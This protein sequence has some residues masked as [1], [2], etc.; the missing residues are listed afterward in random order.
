MVDRLAR[1]G[2]VEI[3]GASNRDI[4]GTDSG[5]GLELRKASWYK[6]LDKLGTMDEV[7]Q[8]LRDT[9]ILGESRIIG[10]IGEQKVNVGLGYTR[11][12]LFCF[13]QYKLRR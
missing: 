10:I 1:S 7:S 6:V 12:T 9:R 8:G 5:A 2:S 11:R 4:F 3:L 13:D